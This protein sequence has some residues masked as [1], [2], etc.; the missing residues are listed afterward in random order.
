MGLWDT[1][2]RWWTGTPDASATA[3]P[4]KVRADGSVVS[5]EDGDY[6]MGDG[7]KQAHYAATRRA[8]TKA[9]RRAEEAP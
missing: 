2:R 9:W 5:P 1:L 7:A 3:L 8:H 4:H 6:S